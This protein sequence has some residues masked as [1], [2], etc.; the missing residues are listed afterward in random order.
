MIVPEIMSLVE[1]GWTLLVGELFG[2]RTSTLAT[3]VSRTSSST[4]ATAPG[5]TSNGADSVVSRLL[6]LA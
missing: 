1:T 2:A 3:K 6:P 5:R 4:W